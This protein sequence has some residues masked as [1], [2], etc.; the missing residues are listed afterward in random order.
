M[1]D[2]AELKKIYEQNGNLEEYMRMQSNES[3]NTMESIMVS[4]DF[5]AGTY[6]ERYYKDPE[7][8]FRRVKRLAEIIEEKNITGSI[9]EA[10]VGEAQT[11]VTILNTMQKDRFQEVYGFDGSWS[12]IKA[13]KK[14]SRDQKQ[15]DINFFTGDMLNIPLQDNSMDLVYTFHAIEPN[16]GK[17]KEILK[18]L[19]RVTA[20]WLILVEPCYEF[21]SEEARERMR[22]LGYITNLYNSIK[23]LEYDLETYELY[24]EQHT[25]LNPAGLTIIRKHNEKEEIKEKESPFACPITKNKMKAYKDSFYCEE[26]MLAYPIVQSIPCLLPMNAIVATKYN[27]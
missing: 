10:G 6:T 26:S 22:K 23:E 13:A 20:R 7:N 12:R 2:L 1:F 27:V 17:E 25:I 18:E 11:L 4:Y 5:Q 16:G 3:K 15:P 8:R 9:L 24:G 21:A 19:Y 14:F